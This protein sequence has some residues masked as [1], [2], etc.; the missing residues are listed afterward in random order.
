MKNLIQSVFLSATALLCCPANGEEAVSPL[1]IVHSIGE[2]SRLWGVEFSPDDKFL[3]VTSGWDNPEEA[4]ELVVWSVEAQKPEL[5]WRQAKTIRCATYSPDGTQLAFGDFDGNIRVLDT[6][7]GKVIQTLPKLSAIVNS[8]VYMPDGK[9]ILSGGFNQHV[10][11]WNLETGEAEKSIYLKDQGIT[12]VAVSKDGDLIAASTWPGNAYVWNTKTLE[13]IHEFSMGPKGGIGEVVDFSP[14]ADLLLT[15]S[16]GR[17]LRVWGLKDGNLIL[18]IEGLTSLLQSAKFSEDGKWLAT[19]ESSGQVKLWNVSDPS[20]PKILSL[21]KN[22]CFGL[23]F[24]SDNKF[25]ATASWDKRVV[26]WNLET[27]EAVSVLER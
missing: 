14:N 26:I 2:P 11:I 12:T 22:R 20:D 24:S 8:L 25:L 16:W 27:L 4:G 1:D 3:A 23:D 13:T 17:D 5:I 15:G 19:G 21:H 18:D 10:T 7:S 6:K 9:K